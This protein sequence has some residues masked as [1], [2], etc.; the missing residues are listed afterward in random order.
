MK[1]KRVYDKELASLREEAGELASLL[2]RRPDPVEAG[3]TADRIQY[4][5]LDGHPA[6]ALQR[7]AMINV[8]EMVRLWAMGGVT[9]E[10]AGRALEEAVSLLEGEQ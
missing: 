10:E 5:C 8:S 3:L 1:E 9:R 7:E 4:A 2:N 6:L